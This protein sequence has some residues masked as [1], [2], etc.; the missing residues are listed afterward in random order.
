MQSIE[1][2]V[3]I[4]GSSIQ[5]FVKQYTLCSL[6]LLLGTLL[7]LLGGTS[8]FGQLKT[9]DSTRIALLYL[10]GICLAIGTVIYF[11]LL[12]LYK[13][14]SLPGDPEELPDVPDDLKINFPGRQVRLSEV[15]TSI[16]AFII[17]K[18]LTQGQ[19]YVSQDDITSKFNKL[20]AEMFFRLEQL[21]L[22][23]FLEKEQIDI[24]RGLPYHKYR[25]S[26]AY[27]K[28]LNSST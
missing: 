5:H 10:G 13:H 6:F 20:G 1:I 23:G 7:I 19:D 25:L 26:S 18:V 8:G 9:N 22:L 4:I 21:R 12:F 24:R 3:K 11:V 15:Q 2:F 14:K 16:L 17:K 27:L 28:H